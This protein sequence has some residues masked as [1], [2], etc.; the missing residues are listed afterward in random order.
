MT[1]SDGL[2]TSPQQYF[3]SSLV[4]YGASEQQETLRFGNRSISPMLLLFVE[5]SDC[6]TSTRVRSVGGP[7]STQRSNQPTGGSPYPALDCWAQ[8]LVAHHW[9]PGGGWIRKWS[10]LPM[11]QTIV[12]HVGGNRWCKRVSR[13][14]RSNNISIVVRIEHRT[15]HQVRQYAENSRQLMC[16]LFLCACCASV[17][18]PL[19]VCW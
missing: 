16:L 17:H 15:F 14:H 3:L 7:R 4:C 12:F 8:Q 18:L 10:L 5:F 1:P 9:G 13:A 6:S 11:S 19:S 2:H